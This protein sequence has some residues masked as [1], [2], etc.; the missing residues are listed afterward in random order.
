MAPLLAALLGLL[1]RQEVRGFAQVYAA[2]LL[3]LGL[4]VGGWCWRT[5]AARWRSRSPTARPSC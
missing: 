1:Y 3:V 4:V 2:L 5:R